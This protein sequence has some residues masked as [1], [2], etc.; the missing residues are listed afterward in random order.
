MKIKGVDLTTKPKNSKGA[1]GL[2]H[3]PVAS[4]SSNG[5]ALTTNPRSNLPP[6]MTAYGAK[7]EEQLPVE[8]ESVQKRIGDELATKLEG[9]AEPNWDPKHVCNSDGPNVPDIS[10]PTWSLASMVKGSGIASPNVNVPNRKTANGAKGKEQL[11]VDNESMPTGTGDHLATKIEGLAMPIW[12]PQQ[13]SNSDGLECNLGLNWPTS[14][15]SLP[16]WSSALPL[17]G[18]GIASPISNFP[19]KVAL[20][21]EVSSTKAKDYLEEK[22]KQL[23]DVKIASILTRP[24]RILTPPLIGQKG[25]GDPR[26]HVL[27]PSSA[28]HGAL[29]SKTTFSGAFCPRVNSQTKG[30]CTLGR[31]GDLCTMVGA[32][33][34][35]ETLLRKGKKLVN[36]REE[37]LQNTLGDTAAKRKGRKPEFSFGRLV[38]ANPTVRKTKISP[39]SA[40]ASK[41]RIAR[42]PHF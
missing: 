28:P 26:P 16:T 18:Y 22:M 29:C 35:D 23:G 8:N 20:A 24:E 19:E 6:C 40:A 13:K 5:L 17:K 7:G 3:Y 1:K 10:L 15:I 4:K 25:C 36:V 38:Y 9:P 14:D 12:D 11:P 39:R 33:I 42:T 21:L 34:P 27:I 41:D 31:N 2:R 37:S 32:T 30:I